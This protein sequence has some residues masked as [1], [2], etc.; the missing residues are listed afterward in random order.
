M[1]APDPCSFPKQFSTD[2]WR[3][4]HIFATSMLCCELPNIIEIYSKWLRRLL[5]PAVRPKDAR[6]ISWNGPIHYK[7]CLN[8]WNSLLKMVSRTPILLHWQ[9]KLTL[10]ASQSSRRALAFE[11]HSSHPC[12]TTGMANGKDYNCQKKIQ[13]VKNAQLKPQAWI[14]DRHQSKADLRLIVLEAALMFSAKP[15]AS[16]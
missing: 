2:V 12:G 11:K 1:S 14:L 6:L 7:F 10:Q 15:R 13:L 9:L 8:A 4:I 16:S 3:G 5:K